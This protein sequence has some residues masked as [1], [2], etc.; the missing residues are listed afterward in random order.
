MSVVAENICRVIEAKQR[1]SFINDINTE[2]RNTK[3][4]TAIT[5]PKKNTSRGEDSDEEEV[6]LLVEEV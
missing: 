5:I 6:S 1:S 3:T 2:S 4:S